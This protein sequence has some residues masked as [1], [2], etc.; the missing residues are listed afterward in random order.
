MRGKNKFLLSSR[1]CLLWQEEFL[2]IVS[3]TCFLHWPGE[4]IPPLQG[5]WGCPALFK[6]PTISIG[7]IWLGHST[8]LHI[9]D[10]TNPF[11]DSSAC[12]ESLLLQASTFWQM[13][14]HSPVWCWIHCRHY[15]AKSARPWNSTAAQIRTHPPPFFTISMRSPLSNMSPQI[16]PE[17][18]T[19][20]LSDQSADFQKCCPLCWCLMANLMAAL[21]LFWL[22]G[23]LSPDGYD[24]TRPLVY[25]R[26][27]LFINE[28][29]ICLWFGASGSIFFLSLV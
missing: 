13:A 27:D 5:T 4:T 25:G 22:D 28:W 20:D 15:H 14:P 3:H 1:Y 9:A 12:L 19:F 26:C 11:I 18:S 16:V 17:H 24:Q 7:L 23:T 2:E 21:S 8:T 10:L 6:S 29:I